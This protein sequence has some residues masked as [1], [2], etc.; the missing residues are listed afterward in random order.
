MLRG[1]ALGAGCNQGLARC[2][3]WR[4]EALSQVGGVWAWGGW[5]SL[6][7]V[8]EPPPPVHP[9]AARPRPELCS[10]SGQPP[11]L[12]LSPLSPVCISLPPGC[13][14]F[15]GQH[16][17][18]SLPTASGLPREVAAQ[19]WPGPPDSDQ[20]LLPFCPQHLSWRVREGSCTQHL[21]GN[22]GTSQR[23]PG[24][25]RA[26]PSGGGGGSAE[27]PRWEPPQLDKHC[28]KAAGPPR[29]S[30]P[31]F[32]QEVT[33]APAPTSQWQVSGGGRGQR[34]EGSG[35]KWPLPAVPS[36]PRCSCLDIS[37]ALGPALPPALP[38]R[39]SIEMQLQ[40]ASG[41]RCGLDLFPFHPGLILNCA[42]FLSKRSEPSATP[43]GQMTAPASPQ[44]Q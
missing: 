2:P 8:L 43:R 7:P 34:G 3:S 27:G 44:P 26:P 35:A 32:P 37:S 33:A 15:L 5:S 25:G 17:L 4:G 39:G 19:T 22:S 9:P 28:P 21:P 11:A 30:P 6:K 36:L 18:P 20:A 14:R 10:L 38:Q 12:P 24:D 31:C 16:L 13:S 29:L 41:G 1:G 40:K 23:G 42:V